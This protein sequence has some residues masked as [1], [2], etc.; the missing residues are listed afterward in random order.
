L[1]FAVTNQN[2]SSPSVVCW[3][4][5]T[6]TILEETFNCDGGVVSVLANQR[7]RL[8]IQF[9]SGTVAN[10]AYDGT[11]TSNDSSIS[12]AIPEFGDAGFSAI[13][14]GVV[15]LVLSIRRRRRSG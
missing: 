6:T 14:I 1:T 15:V 4:N 3:S 12:V 5:K 10:L 11:A 2:G 9:V 13:A 8:R 7:I